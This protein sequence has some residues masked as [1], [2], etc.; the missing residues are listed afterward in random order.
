MLTVANEDA[1]P[2]GSTFTTVRLRTKVI[3][4]AGSELGRFVERPEAAA[5]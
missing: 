3:C 1:N 5:T 2:I 4:G